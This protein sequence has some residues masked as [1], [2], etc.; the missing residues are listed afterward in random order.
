MHYLVTNSPFCYLVFHAIAIVLRIRFTNIRANFRIKRSF[1][2]SSQFSQLFKMLCIRLFSQ[3]NLQEH[4]C[5]HCYLDQSLPQLPNFE[6]TEISISLAPSTSV[7][8][9]HRLPSLTTSV[10]SGCSSCPMS[11]LAMCRATQAFALRRCVQY[12]KL[13][14]IV[15]FCFRPSD[16]YLALSC[17][18]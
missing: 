18:D 14:D 12:E 2:T 4:S 8:S 6:T 13:W 5:R 15:S 9:V 16:K 1:V 10:F 3:L 17:Q 11:I 7:L